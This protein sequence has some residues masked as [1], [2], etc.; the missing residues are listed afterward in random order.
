MGSGCGTP[1]VQFWQ[2]INFSGKTT[3]VCG[4][5]GT[6][7]K[8]GYGIT[9]VAGILGGYTSTVSSFQ[10]YGAC[11]ISEWWTT[12]GV[13]AYGGTWS[14][15]KVGQSWSYLGSFWNDNIGSMKI[16]SA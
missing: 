1:L 3:T 15:V 6:C 11:Q 9:G 2:D 7:D 13:L 16:R 12:T 14:G 8:S 4:D 10:L 5:Y